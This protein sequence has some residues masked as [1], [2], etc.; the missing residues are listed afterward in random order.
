MAGA[1]ETP[2]ERP[3]RLLRLYVILG[4]LTAFGPM[5]IDMYLPALPTLEQTFASSPSRVQLTLT[6]V[7]IGLALGQGVAG[8]LSDAFGRRR[9][10]VIGLA[11]YVLASLLCATP[12]S[13]SVLVAARFL[14]GI[15]AAV[16]L[17]VSRAVVRD[18]FDGR[19]IA[20]V[21]SWLMLVMGAA[22][23]LAPVLGGAILRFSSWPT[24][25]LVLAAYGS[26]VLAGTL[27]VLPETLPPER[28][29]RA[30][31]GDVGRTF[32]LL[33]ADR[34]FAGYALAG[35]L[36]SGSMF[37]YIA[38]SPFV[39]QDMYGV[40]PTAYGLIFGVNAAG[41]ITASQLNRRL[42][43]RFEPRTLLIVGLA[44]SAAGA[45]ALCGVV[46]VG[47]IGLVGILPSFFAVVSMVG[48]VSPNATALALADQAGRAGSASAVLGLI[49][50]S[51]GAAVAPIVGIA[52]DDTA[53]PAAL[54]IAICASGGIMSLRLSRGQETGSLRPASAPTESGAG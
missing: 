22:P 48:L 3:V 30:R 23:I 5:S 49:Q 31:L 45:A 34:T 13:I 51:L 25:F 8:P 20:R 12:S 33:L 1:A 6:A 18:L 27:A 10:L 47:G 14:E 17:V 16:G 35:A 53:V 44:T 26:L 52:G 15:A 21:F 9:L 40:S 7:M 38:A 2:T 43:G 28:R 36:T 4:A 24:I 37:A 39:L 50:F 54:A 42:L 29:H 41:I 11:M 32:G 46:L 19:E